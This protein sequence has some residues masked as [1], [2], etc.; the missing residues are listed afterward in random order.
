MGSHAEPADG[1][2]TFSIFERLQAE[3][4]AMKLPASS[5]TVT[6]K[7]ENPRVCEQFRAL[8]CIGL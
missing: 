8:Q 7:A 4:L 2:M 6:D 5:S 1:L 3:H